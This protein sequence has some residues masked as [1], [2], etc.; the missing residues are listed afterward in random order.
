MAKRVVIIGGGVAGLSAAHELINRG[1]HVDVYEATGCL[2]GKARSVGVPGS[3][4]NG[5]KDLP[6]EHGLRR[7]AEDEIRLFAEGVVAPATDPSVLQPLIQPEAEE[8]DQ[9]GDDDSVDEAGHRVGTDDVDPDRYPGCD[10]CDG[11]EPER[12]HR[13]RCPAGWVHAFL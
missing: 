1:F 3:G 4:K 2:G 8:E 5:R 13:R 7:E 12:Q 11:A 10:A 6:G 9:F